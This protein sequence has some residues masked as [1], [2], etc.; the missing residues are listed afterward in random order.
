MITY[1]N[2]TFCTAKGCA[3]FQHCPLALKPE[4]EEEAKKLKVPIGIFKDPPSCYKP[5]KETKK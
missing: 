5:T 4:T 3:G 1:Q 2:M